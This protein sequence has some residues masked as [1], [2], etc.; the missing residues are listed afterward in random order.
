MV[1]RKRLGFG[2]KALMAAVHAPAGDYRPWDE[3]E[4]WSQSI[5]AALA[6]DRA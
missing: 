6:A 2:E 5:A 4:A 1:D 3:I